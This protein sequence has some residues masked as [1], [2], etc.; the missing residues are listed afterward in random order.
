M[1]WNKNL[2]FFLIHSGLFR[3]FESQ[4]EQQKQNLFIYFGNLNSQQSLPE[5]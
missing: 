3:R 2:S 1:V 5:N 4:Y